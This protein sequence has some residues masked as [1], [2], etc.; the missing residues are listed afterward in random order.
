VRRT[1][2]PRAR[3][4]VLEEHFNWQK[5]SATGGVAWQPGQPRTRLFLSLDPGSIKAEEVICFLRS[6]RRHVSQPVVLLWDRLPGHRSRQVQDYIAAHSDWLH[7]EWLPPYAP[8]LNPV[9]YLWANLDNKHLANFLPDDLAELAGELRRAIRRV[10]RNP[11]IGLSFIEAAG[12]IS[13]G[14]VQQLCKAQ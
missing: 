2:A 4:P 12:L 9:E 14:Y 11:D 3:T 13:K 8:E 5:L 7:Q 10:R 6:L 1:W